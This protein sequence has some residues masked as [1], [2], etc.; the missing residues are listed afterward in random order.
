MRTILVFILITLKTDAYEWQISK[1][2]HNI[3]SKYFSKLRHREPVRGVIDELQVDLV[4]RMHASTQHYE[5]DFDNSTVGKGETP[6]PTCCSSY[7]CQ[8]FDGVT[9]SARRLE[10]TGQQ[11]DKQWWK[12][13]S[14][15]YGPALKSP[16][17]KVVTKL[18][19]KMQGETKIGP[20]L[21]AQYRYLY[22]TTKKPPAW[23]ALYLSSTTT[24]TSEAKLLLH[25][26]PTLKKKKTAPLRD[27]VWRKQQTLSRS[28][29][30]SEDEQDF[31]LPNGNEGALKS[32]VKL[33]EQLQRKKRK[34]LGQPD[35]CKVCSDSS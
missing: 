11:K 26:K 24:T 31:I 15:K 22:Y 6:L 16:Y 35:C 28:G 34:P 25:K 2:W 13:R 14:R 30:F 4:K 23:H 12:S 10:G 33:F 18:E 29:K 17:E 20:P 5:Q 3:A 9:S 1:F 27:K 32:Q 19:R 21:Q 7:T 8:N